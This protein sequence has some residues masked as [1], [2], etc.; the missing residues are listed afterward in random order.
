[1]VEILELRIKNRELKFLAP[2]VIPTSSVIPAYSV[3]PA[4]SVIPAKA[5]ISI[6][7][8][9]VLK[10]KP[11]LEDYIVVAN[12]PY[13]IT[14]PILNHFLYNLPNKPKEMIILMQKD[15]ADKIIKKQ[16][17]KTSVLNLVVDFM[18]EEI[19]EI[20][21]VGASN[22]IPPPRV[23]STVLYFKTR[24]NI[25]KEIVKDFLEIIKL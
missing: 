17:N 10:F 11:N 16:S 15:V 23:E 3:I 21:K 13:Y 1:M 6:Y 18:C 4:S 12:I 7:N 5:G 22:F 9:D 25:N 8:I 24:Q 19:I 20:T 2:S 14:S